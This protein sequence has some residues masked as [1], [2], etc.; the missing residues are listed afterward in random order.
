M[1]FESRQRFSDNPLNWSFRIGRLFDIDVR[2]HIAFLLC[3]VLLV[4]MQ[5]PS[6]EA[7][8]AAPPLSRMLVQ[9]FGLYAIMFFIVLVHEFGHCF[10]ARH[11]GGSADEILLWPLGGLAYTQPPHTA[12]AHMITTVAGPMVNVGFCVLTAIVLMVWVGSFG[13]VPWNPF[14]MGPLDPT[15]SLNTVQIWTMRFF[16][17]SYIIL[18]FNLLPIF[19]FDGGRIVQAALW[20]KLGYERSMLIATTT[21]MV[22]AALLGAV[23]LFTGASWLLLMLA[24][25]GYLTCWQ[26][27]RAILMGG[28]DGMGAGG[29][30]ESEFAASLRDDPEPRPSFWERRR[31]KREERRIKLKEIEEVMRREDLDAVLAK[32]SEQGMSALSPKEKRLLDEET[33]RQQNTT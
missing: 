10:G 3:A 24:V 30:L 5:M 9:A 15:L 13:A 11:T 12:R 2:I 1:H 27:R 4:W 16:S 25:F 19:P 32:I 18:L 14:H 26:T 28:M 33:K 8:V 22:G 31:Q 20:P 17:I 21:G 29:G 7:G 6:R 23:G